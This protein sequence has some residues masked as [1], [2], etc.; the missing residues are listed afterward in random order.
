MVKCEVCGKEFERATS[1]R[2]HMSG[3]SRLGRKRG[4]IKSGTRVYRRGQESFVDQFGYRVL[5]GVQHPLAYKNG[6]VFEHRKVLYD[7][8]GPGPHLCHWGCGRVVVWGGGV[9]DANQL[10]VDHLNSDK[11]CNEPWNLVPSC[12]KCNRFRGQVVKFLIVL[13]IELD[14]KLVGPC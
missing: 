12:N 2:G 4:R 9:S 7:K 10:V 11:L 13:G 1:M 8:I 6:Q 3:H 14:P 5:N